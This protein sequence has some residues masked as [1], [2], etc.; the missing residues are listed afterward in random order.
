MAL[1]RA[2]LAESAGASADAAPLARPAESSTCVARS[3]G[4]FP[5]T[6]RGAVPGTLAEA[7][8]EGSIPSMGAHEPVGDRGGNT[9][10]RGD[11][12][13][14]QA[15]DAHGGWGEGKGG[16]CQGTTG[17]WQRG[18]FGLGVEGLEDDD[19]GDDDGDDDDDDYHDGASLVRWSEELDFKRCES[20]SRLPASCS[21][22]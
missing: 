17:R 1:Y 9:H 4:T 6:V 16:K 21:G 13:G 10:W 5:R 11:V 14:A 12:K 22:L 8:G 18:R 7:R 2:G 3:P 19:D 15:W 20:A